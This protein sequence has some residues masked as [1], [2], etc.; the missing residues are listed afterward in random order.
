M[1]KNFSAVSYLMRHKGQRQNTVG[2]LS[3]EEDR[4]WTGSDSE[5]IKKAVRGGKFSMGAPFI[6][7][8][9]DGTFDFLSEN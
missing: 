3:K 2:W 6:C 9:S 5:L 7:G 8:L 1:R 4:F